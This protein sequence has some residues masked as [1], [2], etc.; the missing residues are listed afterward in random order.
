MNQNGGQTPPD[1][2]KTVKLSGKATEGST[3]SK[4]SKLSQS[5]PLREVE[6]RWQLF[7][8]NAPIGLAHI[9]LHGNI[10]ECNHSLGK[11][12]GYSTDELKGMK[13]ANIT[14]PED[15]EVEKLLDQEILFGKRDSYEIEKRFIHKNGQIIW[16]RLRV[17]I[18]RDETGDTEFLIG[19]AEDITDRLQ[20][21]K[22]HI[23]LFE[24]M[25]Q[26][27]VYQD[28]EG[29]IISANPAAE[30]ILG[31]SFP[32]MT[33]R[34]S[35][36]PRWR[37]AR[38]D[39]SDFPGEEHPAMVALRTGKPMTNVVMGVFNPVVG[40]HRW[41]SVDAIPLFRPGEDTPYQV[42]TTFNDITER[43]RHQAQRAQQQGE[44]ELYASLLRHD[45]GN[46]LQ[47]ILGNID[48]TEMLMV[49]ENAESS[50]RLSSIRAAANRMVNL[51]KALETEGDFEGGTLSQ[52]LEKTA[53]TAMEIHS[54]LTVKVKV[55]DEARVAALTRYRLLNIVC[56]N[57]LRNSVEHAGSNAIVSMSLSLSG[58]NAVI[59]ISDN[60]PG[61][62]KEIRTKLFQ[63]GTSSNGGGLGLYLSRQLLN[64]YN[65]SIE[66]LAARKG[67]GA[68][69]LITIPIQT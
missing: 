66:L 22:R 17:S 16:A 60:G 36:D 63:R 24:T 48:F 3:V 31:L 47:I 9:D 50:R 52:M 38:Q 55:N 8:E 19:I 69:F 1:M 62:P 32:Q 57:L 7:F 61:I 40:E 58:T 39:G 68:R 65:G 10:L 54:G 37:A 25:A 49:G 5:A 26:G 33:G 43:V 59:E 21:E 2:D 12:L 20:E 14:H 41:I 28:N 46:D 23:A 15:W 64:V 6:Q 29:K 11:M 51:L 56:E 42:Y 4:K 44:L 13:I 45:L 18:S 53:E 67:E 35:I 30:R 34:D 27:V